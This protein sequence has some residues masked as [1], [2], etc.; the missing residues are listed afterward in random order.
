MLKIKSFRLLVNEEKIVAKRFVQQFIGNSLVGMVES[1]RL[2]DPSI[3]KID[4]VIEF[5][6]S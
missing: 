4:L 3:R 5:N 1:L 2:K 6:D